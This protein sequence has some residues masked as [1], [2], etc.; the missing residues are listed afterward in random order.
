MPIP[1]RSI[2]A[3]EMQSFLGL[4]DELV[5]KTVPVGAEALLGKL[6]KG[7]NITVAGTYTC[8]MRVDGLSAI[9]VHLTATL[10]ASTVTSSVF[11]TYNDGVTA[12]QNFAGVGALVSVTRQ[13]STLAANKGEKLVVVSL[14]VGA[15]PNI[16]F[17]QAEING[18]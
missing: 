9:E 1:L 2:Q 14:L 12:K 16:T 7:S 11:T 6:V 10:T 3:A 8:E 17:T 4:Q 18:L 15:A 13:S 5:F